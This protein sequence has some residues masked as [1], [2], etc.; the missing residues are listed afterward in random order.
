MKLQFLWDEEKTRKL[1]R[2]H[3]YQLLAAGIAGTVYGFL[4]PANHIFRW[5]IILTPGAI[6][7]VCFVCLFI[8]RQSGQGL[9]FLLFTVLSSGM[10]VIFMAVTG[11]FT[12]VAQL[13]PFALLL[14]TTYQLGSDATVVLGVF[15][16]V[17]FIA[18][19]V[20]L[21]VTNTTPNNFLNFLLYTMI[22]TAA[23][24]N[25]RNAGR[26]VSLQLEA[27]KRLEEIDGLKNQFMVLA[28]HYLRTPLTIIKGFT[29]RLE[30]TPLQPE[31]KEYVGFIRGGS[32]DLETFTEKILLISSIER[33]KAKIV[34][35]P[36]DLNELLTATIAGFEQ[37]ASKNK[38]TLTYL[39]P[40]E[41]LPKLLLDRVG[42]R[43][44]FVILVDN[45][46]RFNK[47]GGSV[48]VALKKTDHT[49][50][51]TIADTGEGISKEHL[52]TLYMP[53]SHGGIE[54]TIAYH[55]AGIGISLYLAKLII[56][57]HGGSI[58]VV[59]TEGEGS[60]FVITLPVP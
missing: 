31:Q 54:K 8:I 48:T 38:I 39:G 58:H 6:I 22:Y 33:G 26:E 9:K 50:S 53:F 20:W 3:L 30:E 46:I 37:S 57:A 51:V 10:A 41:P 28:S 2:I 60:T 36:T 12:S 32:K 47:P 7:P 4:L 40:Q 1:F 44:T 55:K 56:E 27:R 25:E 15:S 19:Q 52:K 11:G 29:A 5:W 24:L 21:M 45:A 42:M 34:P 49:A 17:S 14:V 23:F 35:I 43:E 13:G 18:L 59:S 16:I